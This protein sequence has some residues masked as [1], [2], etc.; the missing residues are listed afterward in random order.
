MKVRMLKL[1]SH[2][3]RTAFKAGT[4]CRS[5]F[6]GLIKAEQTHWGGLCWRWALAEQI[7]GKSNG[8]GHR[9]AP[10]YA[11]EHDGMRYLAYLYGLFQPV[12]DG[13]LAYYL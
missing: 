7:L 9:T 3:A 6:N 10:F 8:K 1:L 13:F 12:Y 5:G 2:Q 11:G 4:F